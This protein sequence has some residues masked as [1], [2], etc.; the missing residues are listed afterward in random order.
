MV[1]LVRV[2]WPLISAEGVKVVMKLLLPVPSDP[3]RW[4]VQLS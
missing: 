3:S 4:S 2:V 1:V